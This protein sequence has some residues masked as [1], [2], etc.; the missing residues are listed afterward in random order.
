[1]DT[2]FENARLDVAHFGSFPSVNPLAK[3]TNDQDQIPLLEE[4]ALSIACA[5]GKYEQVKRLVE[6]GWDINK[7]DPSNISPLMRAANNGH[8]K[9]VEYMISKGAKISYDLLCSVKTKIELLEEQAKIGA[10]D[11][12]AVAVW[13]NFLEYLIDE[14]KKQ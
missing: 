12:Y 11:P 2:D 7:K 8:R 14:G 3:V 4:S 10:E 6:E 5:H 13:K 9:I 1:M